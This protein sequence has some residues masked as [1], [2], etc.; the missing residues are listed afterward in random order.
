MSIYR[1]GYR[2][3]DCQATLYNHGCNWN[4]SI[5]SYKLREGFAPSRTLSTEE[6][7]DELSSFVVEKMLVLG[8]EPMTCP[9]LDVLVS[10]AKE[11]GAK[12]RIAHSNGSILPPDGVDEIGISL[13]AYSKK[14]H[15]QL[16]GTTN[17]KVLGNIYAIHDRG[18]PMQVSTILIPQIVGRDEVERIASFLADVDTDLPFHV[19][20]YLPVPGIPW[21]RPTRDEVA[22]A[23][24]AA[25]KHLK[26]VTWS[27]LSVGDYLHASSRDT[28]QHRDG[29]F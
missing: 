20:S 5:C 11:R 4:C 1:V 13:R 27:S 6:V 22:E 23:V 9:D 19:S 26:N 21:R 25:K 28:M 15:Q 8:G 29:V 3:E 17:T 12:V 7:L 2:E 18:I 24:L 10:S 14:K 16:T